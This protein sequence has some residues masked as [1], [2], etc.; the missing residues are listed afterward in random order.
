TVLPR[1]PVLGEI[2]ARLRAAGARGVALSGSG[3]AVFGVFTDTAARDAA[4]ARL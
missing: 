2:A 1:Y 4:L 3:A